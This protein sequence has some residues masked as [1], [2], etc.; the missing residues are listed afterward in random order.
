VS[1][2][3]VAFP[4]LLAAVLLAACTD[5]GGAWRAELVTVP[6][7]WLE[8]YEPG[9]RERLAEAR[10]QLD[11]RLAQQDTE[12]AEA[13]SAFG[14]LGR[15]YAAHELFA[16]ARACF[17]NAA[18]LAPEDRRWP[19]L[20]AVAAQA[21][22]Q[23]EAAIA[24][25]RRTLELAPGD[26]P[27]L[28]RL[29]E[30]ELERHG[31][32]AAGAA[33]AAALEDPRTAVAAEFGLGR[34]AAARGDDEAA[35]RHFRSV[36]E[37]QPQASAVRHPLAMALRRRGDE[38]AAREQLALAGGGQ[39][40]SSD[41]L[42]DALSELVMGARSLLRRGDRARAAGNS[43]VA[44]RHYRLAV[45]ADPGFALAHHA[46]GSLLGERGETADALRH[47]ERA[48]E[49][50]A[51][52]P[53]AWYD[54]ATALLRERRQ[55]EAHAALDEVLRLD[56]RHHEALLR[57]AA[58]WRDRGEL[59]R[60]RRDLE[61]ILEREPHHL[62]AT[63]NL[64]VVLVRSGTPERAEAALRSALAA[65]PPPAERA[66]LEAAR[67]FVATQ[68]GDTATALAAYRRAVDASPAYADGWF[69]LAVLLATTGRHDEAAAA[70]AE[71]VSRQPTNARAHLGRAR[72][73][74]ALARWPQAAATLEDGLR[75]LPSDAHLA[76]ALAELLAACPDPTLR[77]GT[78]ALQLAESAYRLRPDAEVAEVVAMALAELGRYPEATAVTS[79]LLARATELGAPRPV[80]ERLQAAHDRYRR[81][82][83]T[84]LAVP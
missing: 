30:I 59:D 20:L 76:P 29:G 46:L 77:D 22:G 80:I 52:F 56:P 12:R 78:R 82:E 65:D 42:V 44:L 6:E 11:R 33:F 68:R 55:A 84:R 69:N 71:V 51:D 43:E 41:E 40:T 60:A 47:L 58:L 1:G 37:R 10:R 61:A 63:E 26:G 19:Y 45:A 28:L 81:G 72:S 38:E 79:Q 57:R 34:V 7:V 15:V 4:T 62:E 2:R 8:P 21:D 35:V 75:R 5:D 48:T 67:G 70:F 27:A 13:A 49:L 73:Q 3:A 17:A 36:L 66:R 16:A 53:E 64:A 25:L 14:H 39:V 18:A 50:D 32:E 83:P 54:L 9:D 23:P 31:L 74:M 24:H